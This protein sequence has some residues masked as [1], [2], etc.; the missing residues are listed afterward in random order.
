M[1][2]L[3]Q[4][5]LLSKGAERRHSPLLWLWSIFTCSHAGDRT[6]VGASRMPSLRGPSARLWCL[7]TRTLQEWRVLAS[8]A[9]NNYRWGAQFDV[10]SVD[11]RKSQ[12]AANSCKSPAQ[13]GLPFTLKSPTRKA[14]AGKASISGKQA[15]ICGPA[16]QEKRHHIARTYYLSLRC[17]VTCADDT[18]LFS[19]QLQHIL[20]PKHSIE[21]LFCKCPEAS[22]SI[23]RTARKHRHILK[24]SCGL[25]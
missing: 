5:A 7:L 4:D 23:N 17:S 11:C 6:T 13:L 12:S 3:W 8:R 14:V 2:I 21:H 22:S 15:H 19:G 18:E 10:I 20:A 24:D 1:V 9:V 16:Q 25:S